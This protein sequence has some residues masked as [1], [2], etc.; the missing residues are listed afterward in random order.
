MSNSHMADEARSAPRVLRSDASRWQREAN[1]IR[2]LVAERA[3]AVLVGRGSSG[4]VCTFASY[5]F[6]LQTGRQP[7]SFAPGLRPSPCPRLTGM[8]PSFMHFL[9]RVSRLTSPPALSGCAPEVH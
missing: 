2:R 6:A 5:L 4:N 1:D 7:L 9:T 8:T 3:T